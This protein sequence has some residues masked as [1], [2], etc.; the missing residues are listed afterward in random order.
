MRYPSKIVSVSSMNHSEKVFSQGSISDL[1]VV[2]QLDTSC[3]TSRDWSWIDRQPCN[4]MDNYSLSFVT[5]KT[6]TSRLITL[7][8]WPALISSEL[9]TIQSTPEY[10]YFNGLLGLKSEVSSNL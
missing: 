4:L 7:T 8:V 5:N 6:P 2:T 9:F 3:H 10:L 1:S